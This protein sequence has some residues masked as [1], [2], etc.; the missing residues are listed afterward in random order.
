MI[1]KIVLII[2]SGLLLPLVF[3]YLTRDK[4]ELRYILSDR[5][6]TNL[7][8]DHVSESIQQIELINTGDI[9]VNRVI[10]KIKAQVIDF[11]IQKASIF[12]SIS[13]SK[14]NNEFDIL[15]PTIPPNGIVKVVIK[16][17]DTGF[18]NEN[19]SIVHTKG[20]GVNVLKKSDNSMLTYILYL[21]LPLIY[22]ILIFY[23]IRSIAINHFLENAYLWPIEILKENKPLFI[24]KQNWEKTRLAAINF[25]FYKDSSSKFTKSMAYK[26]LSDEKPSYLNDEEWRNMKKN[27][28]EDLIK[29]VNNTNSSFQFEEFFKI[30]KPMYIDDN[31]WDKVVN[32]INNGFY[33]LIVNNFHSFMNSS[34]FKTKPEIINEI[35]WVKILEYKRLKTVE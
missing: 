15:Y 4:I 22:I 31:E 27:A 2:I 6:P 8:E 9:E 16:S 25:V 5:I 28:E 18:G 21:G 29:K 19:L 3:F 30:K 13:V 12:D 11:S 23:Q 14:S 26:I 10:I 24:S 32:A 33:F 20:K 35:T 17:T 7:H 34:I 1:N